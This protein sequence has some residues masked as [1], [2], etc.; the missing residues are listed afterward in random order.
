M[1]VNVFIF[2]FFISA[3]IDAENRRKAEQAMLAA[4]SGGGG[5]GSSKGAEVVEEK[6]EVIKVDLNDAAN[7]CSTNNSTDKI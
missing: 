6:E 5:G 7:T 4:T 1:F 2:L 3:L